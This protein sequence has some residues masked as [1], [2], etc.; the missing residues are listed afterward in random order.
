VKPQRPRSTINLRITADRK[1]APM[2]RLF[3]IRLT[4]L[5]PATRGA[6]ARWLTGSLILA[7][8]SCTTPPHSASRSAPAGTDGALMAAAQ[9]EGVVRAARPSTRPVTRAQSSG[10]IQQVGFDDSLASGIEPAGL[11]HR[12]G[13]PPVDCPPI[14][15]GQEQRVPLIQPGMSCP[16]LQGGVAYG[17]PPGQNC[18]APDYMPS[19]EEL[20]DEYICDGGDQGNPVFYSDKVRDGIDAQDTFATFVSGNGESRVEV[21]NKVCL[22]APRFSAVRSISSASGRDQYDRLGG[23]TEDMR[24]AGYDARMRFEER[25]QRDMPQGIR[26]RDRASGLSRWQADG[27]YVK[28]IAAENHIKLINVFEDLVFVQDGLLRRAEAATIAR[29]ALAA[30]EWSIDQTPVIVAEDIGGQQL[31]ATFKAEEYVG[32]EDP[33]K[34]DD[35]RICKLADKQE[36]LPGDVVTFTL[37]IDNLGKDALHNV[38]VTDSLT[39]RLELLPESL[40]CDLPGEF[41][42]APNKEGSSMIHFT[43]KDDLKGKTGGVITFQCRVR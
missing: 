11:R 14:E 5:R 17:C 16:P 2:K 24:I 25:A 10:T 41:S 4:S 23:V 18:P 6:A 9:E 32:I 21:S 38:V 37:R 34:S 7:S 33:R 13:A 35:L 22:Y 3:T 26:V 31:K 15:F 27:L 1:D 40:Q 29:L 42:V 39:P 12:Y 36:A 28:N 43:L 20:S 30:G 8:A 19:P